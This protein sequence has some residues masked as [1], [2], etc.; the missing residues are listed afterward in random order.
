MSANASESEVT[1]MS[2]LDTQV[3]HR[4]LSIT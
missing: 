2:W 4:Q 3:I 1:R